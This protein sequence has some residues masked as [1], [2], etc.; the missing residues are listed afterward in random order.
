MTQK[1]YSIGDIVRVPYYH[2]SDLCVIMSEEYNGEI[3][4]G[5]IENGGEEWQYEV[6]NTVDNIRQTFFEKH[7]TRGANL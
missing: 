3:G 5:V 4:T 1:K 7:I 2:G 6:R